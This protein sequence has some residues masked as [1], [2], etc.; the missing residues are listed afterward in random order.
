MCV[1]AI[2]EQIVNKKCR[3]IPA[4]HFLFR[5][6]RPQPGERQTSC[7]SAP[8]RSPLYLRIESEIRPRAVSIP[9]TRT[10]TC[11]PRCTTSAGEAT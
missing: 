4:L 1:R 11:C 2:N 3:D 10:S 6:A 5:D 7:L 9:V 8:V